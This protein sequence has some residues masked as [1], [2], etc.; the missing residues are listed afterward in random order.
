VLDVLLLLAVS[1]G[2]VYLV[3]AL[4]YQ[5]DLA[6]AR[7]DSARFRGLTELS[8]DWFW[9]TDADHRLRWLSGGA[10]VSG[11]FSSCASAPDN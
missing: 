9:E 11:C 7:T 4:R 3:M 5:K 10:P 1:A 2:A 6:A 8:A